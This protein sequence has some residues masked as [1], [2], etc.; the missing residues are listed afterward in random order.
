MPRPSLGFVMRRGMAVGWLSVV[1]LSPLAAQTD[2]PGPRDGQIVQTEYRP[3]AAEPSKHVEELADDFPYH[4][5]T[6]VHAGTSS[7]AMKRQAVAELSLDSLTPDARQKTQAVLKGMSLY[8][9]LPT[10]SFEVDR[11]MY[12]HFLK[13]PDVV[14]SSWRAMGISRLSLETVRPQYYE[15]DAGDGSKG[16]V[17]VFYSTPEDTLIYCEGAFKSPVLP[18]PIIAKSVMRLRSKFHKEADG[19]I[20]ATHHGDVFVEFPSQTV[21]T[22]AKVISPISYSI[23]DK[24]FKQLTFYAHMMTLAME[25]Q[26]GWVEAVAGR[27]DDI[28]QEQREEFLKLAAVSYIAAKRRE[29]ARNGHPLSLDDVIRPLKI[30]ATP[31]GSTQK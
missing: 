3:P 17:E 2:N 7:G 22:I 28:S 30:S 29:A 10:I 31:S 19:R 27:M 1:G 18:K 9:R 25:R 8:R 12:A 24:N 21:E 26:P 11:N 16:T 14:V 23:A 5:L 20:I 4:G 13:N 15:A 6:I